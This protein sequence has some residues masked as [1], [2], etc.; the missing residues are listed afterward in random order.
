MK[1][2]LLANN[3]YKESAS[4]VDAASY[5]QK[6]LS[7]TCLK[8]IVQPISDGGDGFLGVCQ[9]NYD[10]DI[11]SFTIPFPYLE[12]INM[13]VPV[14]YSSKLKAIFIESSEVLGLKKIPPAKRHPLD[15]SS[16]G[17]GN[18]LNKIKLKF[19]SDH[20]NRIVIG[21]GGTGTIDMGI[22]A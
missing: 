15:L 22:G 12:H 20:L 21:I 19:N 13:I 9:K 11:I 3:S 14:G 10:L 5:F 8:I 6:Y 4:S 16:V 2:I 7:T 18:L 1:K 17:L